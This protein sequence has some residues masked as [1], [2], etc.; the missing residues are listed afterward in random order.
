[1]DC[2]S[3]DWMIHAVGVSSAVDFGPVDVGE[4]FAWCV[5]DGIEDLIG[6]LS[7]EV[8]LGGVACGLKLTVHLRCCRSCKA[9]FDHQSERAEV[10]ERDHRR[11]QQF[12]RTE[13][14]LVERLAGAGEAPR[15]RLN[16]FAEAGDVNIPTQ[17]TMSSG[18]S[19]G[20]EGHQVRA[21][22]R[23]KGRADR[24]GGLLADVR[25]IGERVDKV[26]SETI[27]EENNYVV[28]LFDDIIQRLRRCVSGVVEC[29]GLEDAEGFS[30]GETEGGVIWLVMFGNDAIEL[31][32]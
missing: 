26:H 28:G 18:P 8:S 29:L 31:V 17:V 15:K 12:K 3:S 25:S 16:A 1:M 2:S 32:V 24:T 23:G 30:D 10:T 9:L 22:R 19:A 4:G 14:D 7:D 5:G 27:D 13:T 6:D 21:R 11:E 20:G